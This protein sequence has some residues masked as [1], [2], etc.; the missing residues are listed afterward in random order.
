[1]KTTVI[2]ILLIASIS[3]CTKTIIIPPEP[4]PMPPR[5]DLPVIAEGALSCA[6]KA[7]KKALRL[8]ETILTGRVK[9]LE[10]IILS[11]H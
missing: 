3:G 5:K 7:V 4:L 11:T 2:A 8:R 10:G 9:I 6:G 1:M